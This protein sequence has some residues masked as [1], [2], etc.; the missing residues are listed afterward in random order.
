VQIPIGYKGV[1]LDSGFR[2]DVVVEETVVVELKAKKRIIPVYDAQ[3]ITYLKLSGF[4]IGLLLNFYVPVLKD[5][6]RR[7]AH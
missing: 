5:G 6:I 3:M 2:I 7:F 1:R 4:K